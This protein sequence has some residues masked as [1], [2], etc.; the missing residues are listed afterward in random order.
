MLKKLLKISLL[1][2]LFF[3]LNASAESGVQIEI[4]PHEG[5]VLIQ[6]EGSGNLQFKESDKGY[7]KDNLIEQSW[8]WYPSSG[9]CEWFR[10]C[11]DKCRD[12]Y[13]SSEVREACVTLP[14]TQV[15]NLRKMQDALESLDLHTLFIDF[16]T[17]DLAFFIHF[18][19]GSVL[20]RTF[21]KFSS[22]ESK[23]FL[24]WIAA[25]ENIADYFGGLIG[26]KL[27]GELLSGAAAGSRPLAK[28]LG[29]PIAEQMSF[30][31]IALLTESGDGNFNALSLAHEFFKKSCE[32]TEEDMTDENISRC[33]FQ[34]WYCNTGVTDELWKKLIDTSRD[35]ESA[36][37]DVL[38]EFTTDTPPAWWTE[39]VDVSSISTPELKTL[40]S[41]S[42]I[43]KTEG[44]GQ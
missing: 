30:F 27:F 17:S 9:K 13:R 20:R 24:T 11:I 12:I 35:F 21:D 18:D 40:C 6:V 16:E 14:T 44:A 37:Y 28:A 39:D 29:M 32:E 4:K 15:D 31:E 41:M 10:S 33:V 7:N 34:D 8:A 42:L 5:G 22:S 36:I 25:R 3:G 2:L 43:R 38:Y 23:E 1:G 26:I 19:G